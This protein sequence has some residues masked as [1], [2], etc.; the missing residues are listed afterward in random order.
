MKR[1]E[2]DGRS[3]A[4]LKLTRGGRGGSEI[5]GDS[6]YNAAV[7]GRN[8]RE[9]GNNEVR[10]GGELSGVLRRC[11]LPVTLSNTEHH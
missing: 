9:V 7:L 8:V 5:G 4:S 1:E 10:E 11:D 3:A 6:A 2:I